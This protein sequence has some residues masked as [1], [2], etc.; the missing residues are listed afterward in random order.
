MLV[1]YGLG[2]SIIRLGWEWDGGW[3]P[4][5][6]MTA[7]DAA[8]YA[9]SWQQIVKTMKAVPGA[10]KLQ[11]CWNG[12]G[13]NK[14]FELEAAYPGDDVVDYVGLDIYDK[15]WMQGGY[16]YP[17]GATDD[18]KLEIQKKV[19]TMLYGNKFGIKAWIDIAKAHKKG[20][21]IPEW[22][23]ANMKNGHGGGDDLYFVQ[24]MYNLIQD[25]ANNV[26]E[27]AYWDGREFK[28]VP[29]G[30]MVSQFPKSW[31]LFVKLFSLPP[32]TPTAT[33]LT[34]PPPTPEAS[35]ASLSPVERAKVTSAPPPTTS[36]ATPAPPVAPNP[37]LINNPP[38]APAAT[39]APAAP[40]Q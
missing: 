11:F 30:G 10:E 2:N 4:W 40:A 21:M 33:G 38:A 16:P 25:P 15:A 19:W 28:I 27:A 35:L 29:S 20:F 39:N 23:L 32:G 12:A 6:V 17:A 36:P 34:E 7:E 9:A 26:Y 13:E 18:Q 5:R 31:E 22:G 3:Y 37:M 14:K 8:N 24:Q 1:Q